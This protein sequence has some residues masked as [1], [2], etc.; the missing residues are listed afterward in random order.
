MI[1]YWFE[2]EQ[3]DKFFPRVV[4]GVG[5]GVT[6]YDKNDAITL[7]QKTVFNDRTMPSITQ[8]IEN[9]DISE[10]D[11]SHVLPNMGNVFE[12][13]VWFPLGHREIV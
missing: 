12:R 9:V 7:L 1:R 6:A 11:E 8:I 2:F 4:V 5:C 13:G 3:D 10:L